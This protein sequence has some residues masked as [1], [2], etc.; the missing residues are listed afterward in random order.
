MKT[1]A[2]LEN[3][4]QSWYFLKTFLHWGVWL[5]VTCVCER[6]KVVAK[7]NWFAQICSASNTKFKFKSK[8]AAT[9]ADENKISNA[10]KGKLNQIKCK[11][12]QHSDEIRLKTSWKALFEA[13]L[14]LWP[15]VNKIKRRKVVNPSLCRLRW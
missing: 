7:L 15:P 8:I 13:T 6:V 1:A 3:L 10:N 2:N 11:K 5:I 9:A 4:W 12:Q 14:F